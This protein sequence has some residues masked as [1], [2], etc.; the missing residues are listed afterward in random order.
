MYT[1]CGFLSW[2]KG[3]TPGTG[4]S[5]LFIYVCQAI[6]WIIL[7]EPQM[8]K[9]MAQAPGSAVD[10]QHKTNLIIVLEVF[11]CFGLVFCLSMPCLGALK[12]RIALLLIYHGFWFFYGFSVWVNVCVSLYFL[13]FFFDFFFCLFSLF[14]FVFVLILYAYLFSNEGEK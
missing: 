3:C 11:F 10:G 2:T 1:E 6:F 12:K 5:V 7:K 14:L 8:F 9:N 13:C 4:K